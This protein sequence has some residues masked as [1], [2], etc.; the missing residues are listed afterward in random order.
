MA[1]AAIENDKLILPS[2]PDAILKVL[3]ALDDMDASPRK[4]AIELSRDPALTARIIKI[5]NSVSFQHQCPVTDLNQI[6]PRLGI[7]LIKTLATSHMI[8]QLFAQPNLAHKQLFDQLY[9]NSLNVARYAYALARY[10]Q[11]ISAEDALVAGLMVDIGY[12]PLLLN[13]GD[14]TLDDNTFD[15]FLVKFHSR[16]GAQLLTKWHVPEAIVLAVAEHEDVQRV[17]ATEADLSDVVI[18][19]NQHCRENGQGTNEA[20]S[21]ISAYDRLGI[22]RQSDFSELSEYLAIADT[23]LPVTP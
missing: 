12:L 13:L 1:E 14:S 23:L 8:L 11:T 17:S 21:N 10:S 15:D 2:P 20:K 6:I 5:A 16:V 19:A 4:I 3:N 22:D 18:V 9:R 7:K